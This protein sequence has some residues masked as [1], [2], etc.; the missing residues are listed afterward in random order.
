MQICLV[1]YFITTIV[2]LGSS[3][4]VVSA[5]AN[6]NIRFQ[7]LSPEDG[8]SQAQVYNVVQDLQGYMWFGTLAGL[9]RFDGY[10]VKVFTHDPENAGSISDN[11]IRAILV[12][13]NGILWLGTDSGG[14]SKYNPIDD[15]FTNY[16]HSDNPHSISTNR[17]RVLFED[18]Q[19][20]FWVGTDGAGLELFDRETGQFLHPGSTGAQF[21]NPHIWALYEDQSG[22]LWVGT[23]DGLNRFNRRTGLIT[24]YINDQSDPTSISGDQIRSL[25]QDSNG[26]IWIGTDHSGLNKYDH[27]AQEADSGKFHRYLHQPDNENSLSDDRVTS[28]FEDKQ[29]ALWIGTS[30]GLN[31]LS[32]G[33]TRFVRYTHDLASRHSISHNTI[34]SIYQDQGGVLW[35]G[36]YSGLSRWNQAT[37]TMDYFNVLAENEGSFSNAIITSFAESHSGEIWVGTVGDGLHRFD[38]VARKSERYIGGTNDETSLRDDQV[39][40]LL[41]DRGGNLWVGTR[42]SGLSLLKKGA[43]DFVQFRHDPDDANSLGANGI[44]DIMEDSRGNIWIGTYT[45]GL[46]LLDP[47]TGKIHRFQNSP[48]SSESLSDNRIMALFEDSDGTLWIGTHGGGLNSFDRNTLTFQNFQYDAG[49]PTSISGNNVYAINEDETGNLWIGT[50]SR[51]LNRWSL[52]D[53]R[54]R[55]NN[56]QRYL[57]DLADPTVNALAMDDLGRLWLSSNKGLSQLDVETETFRH[58]DTTHGLDS[59]FMQG[60]TL[61]VSDGIL[62]FGG[63]TGFNFFDPASLVI[64][65]HAPQIVISSIATLNQPIK[66]LQTSIRQGL[67]LSYKDYL[68]EFQFAGLDFAAPEKNRYRYKLEGLDDQWVDAGNRRYASYTNLAPGDYTFMVMA[69]NY[70]GIWSDSPATVAIN[71]TPA[72]WLTWYAYLIYLSIFAMLVWVVYRVQREKILHAVEVLE[73]NRMLEIEVTAGKA[74]ENA[75]ELEKEKAQS[76]LEIADIVM[77]I[78]DQKGQVQLINQRGCET[79]GLDES[80]IT[81]MPW[82]QFV[83]SES[84]EDMKRWLSGDFSD[85][86]EAHYECSLVSADRRVYQ[87][88]WR[89]ASLPHETGEG[90]FLLASGMDVTD[91]RELEKAIHVREKLAAV[92]T[93]A[94]GIAHDFNNILTAINGYSLL[95]MRELTDQESSKKYLGRVVEAT[96]RASDLVTRLLSFS[97][98]EEQN[99]QPSDLGPVLLEAS[100]LLRGSLQSTIEMSVHINPD[101]K[102]V[103]A[104]P[105]QIHQLLMNLGTNAGKAIRGQ[106]GL[107]E[108][109]ASTDYINASELPAHSKLKAGEYLR[110]VVRDNGIGM[111]DDI[112]ETIFD[113]FFTTSGLGFGEKK[114]T[115]LGLS[116]VHGVVSGHSGHIDVKSQPGEG[117]TFTVLLPCCVDEVEKHKTQSKAPSRHSGRV[118]VVD[119][120]E[121][122]ADVSTQ[123]LQALGYS[124]VCFLEPSDAL[125]EFKVQTNG[126][127]LVICDQ[128]MPNMLGTQF[129]SEIRKLNP[130]IPIILMSANSSPLETT[131]ALTIYMKKP[132]TIDQLQERVNAALS[133]KVDQPV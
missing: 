22:D 101:L 90:E 70:D 84:Q 56:F 81:G 111:N 71:V 41:V 5:P 89:F 112:L 98:L 108:I 28:L 103:N 14:L 122:V 35:V 78:I 6:S 24:R 1:R 65:D 17:V 121:W 114:G 12:D 4:T 58:F 123:L 100:V 21:T 92:D 95:A 106:D 67:N 8:L 2:L 102:P 120:E 36:T 42:S 16:I 44:T 37:V 113:P 19:G 10:D 110:L 32:Q 39:M 29:G 20:N 132:F 40:S 85:D 80:Q 93:M 66:Q 11:A 69:A 79:L 51:G 125:Q 127:D 54:T 68:I 62:Y 116:V 50:Q 91:K 94:S 63:F 45:G 48:H 83:H 133:G 82:L 105:T 47:A 126:F 109:L 130:K 52:Q 34:M 131:D 9:N 43:K 13:S 88:M 55:T 59:E 99:L 128:N 33:Q 23:N 49:I 57:K 75:L 64:S 77:V 26:N 76:Y 124:T 60:A 129:V 115:G 104:D 118:L 117:T 3:A 38:P 18:S 31:S 25:L 15:S 46:N 61:T 86:I 53:R 107:L 74:K 119:D 97:N 7:H 30:N 73:I 96:K 72:P 87:I 27:S